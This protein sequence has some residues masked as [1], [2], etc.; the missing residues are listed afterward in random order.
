MVDKST[1][2]DILGEAV[3]IDQYVFKWNTIFF[4][5]NTLIYER[6]LIFR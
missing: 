5:R 1:Y 2:W 4:Y 6:L 3:E